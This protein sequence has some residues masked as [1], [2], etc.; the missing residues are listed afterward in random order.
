MDERVVARIHFGSR[1][2]RTLRGLKSHGTYWLCS[3]VA[4]HLLM[5]TT[6]APYKKE[7]SWMV[8]CMVYG[9]RGLYRESLPL[10]DWN[11]IPYKDNLWNPTNWIERR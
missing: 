11:V 4:R 3:K 2:V 10:S 5:A 8:D 9:E 6:S 7:D 1:Q